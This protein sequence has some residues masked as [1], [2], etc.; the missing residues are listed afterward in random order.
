MKIWL[1]TI[2]SFIIISLLVIILGVGFGV[3]YSNQLI[4]DNKT[5]TN[6]LITSIK[7]DTKLI[8][9]CYCEECDANINCEYLINNNLSGK[10]CGLYCGSI[11]FITETCYIY[12]PNDK[13][14]TVFVDYSINNTTY[15]SNT[16]VE[17]TRSSCTYTVGNNKSCWYDNNNHYDISF[18][19]KLLY[20]WYHL[21]I[22]VVCITGV[23]VYLPL[24]YFIRNNL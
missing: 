6:C 13:V 2:H 16:T 9:D 19:L 5:K 23:I 17:C 3:I 12:L 10:C 14:I 24:F 21:F 1:I 8:R 22:I 18:E 11:N 15:S 7:N 20:E 4:N